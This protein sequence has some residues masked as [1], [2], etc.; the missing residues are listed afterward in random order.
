MI[1]KNLIKTFDRYKEAMTEDEFESFC[2]EVLDKYASWQETLFNV[3][4]GAVSKPIKMTA[5]AA[6]FVG[7]HGL[8]LASKGVSTVSKLPGAIIGGG[9]TLGTKVMNAPVIKQVTA[10]IRTVGGVAADATKAVASGAVHGAGEGLRH[11]GSKLTDAAWNHPMAAGVA[12]LSIGGTAH[13]VG[14]AL[15]DNPNALLGQG[16]TGVQTISRVNSPLGIYA[17]LFE[18]HEIDKIAM[19]NDMNRNREVKRNL[20]QDKGYNGNA[21]RDNFKNSIN[22][23]RPNNRGQFNSFNKPRQDENKKDAWDLVPPIAGAA[24]A[25]AFITTAIQSKGLKVPVQ[26][27][28]EGIT[29]FGL[30]FPKT[31]LKKNPLGKIFLAAAKKGSK[32]DK[33][34]FKLSEEGKEFMQQMPVGE[35]DAI[36]NIVRTT[37]REQDQ[38]KPFQKA[39]LFGAGSGLGFGLANM[40]VHAVGGEYLKR[41]S[42]PFVSNAY[43]NDIRSLDLHKGK[44]QSLDMVPLNQITKPDDKGGRNN[45]QR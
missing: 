15:K 17:S 41:K 7:G 36:K 20:Y 3:A 45:E 42:H 34:A 13:E 28:Q 2:Q 23:G 29:D 4:K 11:A 43:K 22:N 44:F 16:D 33:D 1:D 18:D 6:G 19:V 27:V 25:A 38:A 32:A 39:V 21:M 12:A 9:G 14:K 5:D 37:V 10:P 26:A 31:V 40:G 30:K 24:L 35:K 8:N